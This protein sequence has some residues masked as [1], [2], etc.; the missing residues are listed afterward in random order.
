MSETVAFTPRYALRG[1]VL[2][3]DGTVL[4]KRWILEV[5][6]DNYEAGQVYWAYGSWF[7]LWYAR[8]AVSCVPANSA[9]FDCDSGTS[10]VAVFLIWP[11]LHWVGRVVPKVVHSGDGPFVVNN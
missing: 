2:S 4:A 3:V 9:V 8:W 6:V 11:F 7:V 10:G 1:Y 5:W